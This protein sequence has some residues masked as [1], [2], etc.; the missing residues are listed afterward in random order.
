MKIAWNSIHALLAIVPTLATA[1]VNQKITRTVHLAST[2]PR[3]LI[4]IIIENDTP[5]IANEYSLW[6]G[7]DAG[8][9]WLQATETVSGTRLP[10]NQKQSMYKICN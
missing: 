9:A 8:V 1:L 3:E 2:V 6:V 10:V 5:K 7:K 4:S